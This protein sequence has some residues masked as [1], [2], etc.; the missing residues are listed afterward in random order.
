MNRTEMRRL[1]AL[2]QAFADALADEECRSTVS[3]NRDVDE[4]V[5]SNATVGRASD[6]RQALHLRDPDG[7]RE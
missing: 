5:L 7:D 6:L 3:G 1:Q 2:A 4:V